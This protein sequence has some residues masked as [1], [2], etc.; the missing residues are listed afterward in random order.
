MKKTA[1]GA[2]ALTA[3]AVLGLGAC[4]SSPAATTSHGAPATGGAPSR[5]SHPSTPAGPPTLHV[6]RPHWRLSSPIGR[7]AIIDGGSDVTIAG[8]LVGGDSSTPAAWRLSV[9]RGHVGSL[10]PLAVP[11]HD[12]AGAL[13]NGRP[14]VIGGGNAA[15]QSVVQEWDGHGWQVV[16]HLPEARSDLVAAT[17]GDHVYVLGG[18]NGSRPAEPDV[19]SST[20]GKRWKVVGRLPLP[21]RYAASTVVDGDVWL[22]GGERNDVEQTAVQ[23]FDPRTGHSKV[24]AHLPRPV[25]HAV[26]I[27]LGGRILIAGGRT[28][29]NTVTDRMWWFDPATGRTRPAGHLPTP[30]ADAAV[31]RVGAVTYVVGGESP[32]PTRQVLAVTD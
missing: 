3:T 17:I 20:D 29:P 4:G 5:P 8:G 6:R 12:T 18:Y 16:G 28:D 23:R 21:V 27:P 31:A 26:A 25:G 19:L 11:V 9:G 2:A 15:E 1:L 14:L 24:V 22:F 7:E 30:L 10:P 32:D 13:L